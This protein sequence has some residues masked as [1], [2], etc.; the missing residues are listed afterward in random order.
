MNDPLRLATLHGLARELEG[1]GTEGDVVEC[2]V[3]RGGSAAVLAAA[4]RDSA[5]LLWLYDSFEGMPA[6]GPNDPAAARAET[7]R[8][9]VGTE[10]VRAALRTVRFPEDRLRLRQ[11]PFRE[12]FGGPR[13]GRV[14]LLHIDADWHDSVLG[15]LE[16]FYPLVSD[17]GWIVLDDFGH[18]EGARRA[19]YA[20]CRSRRIE[21]LLERTGYTQAFWRKGQETNRESA[22]RYHLGLYRPRHR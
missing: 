20:F 19:F 4:I 17:G 11:G 2:G 5:R 12:T 7:G 18:W 1:S 8:L 21:P 9:A 3:C 14:A 15:A 6:P 10:P 22:G 16:A 13:P